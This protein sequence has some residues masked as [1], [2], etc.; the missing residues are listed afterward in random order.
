MKGPRYCSIIAVTS[1]AVWAASVAAQEHQHPPSQP[2]TP[3]PDTVTPLY[4]NLGSLHH[5]I[6]TKSPE[7]QRYFDQGLRLT[8]G[9]NHEE[10]VRSFERAVQLD[11]D[12]A[13]C[14]W[15]IAY[16]LG[17]NINLPMDAKIEPRALEA[18]RNAARLKGAVTAG[19]RAL[20]EAMAVRYGEPAG[21]SRAE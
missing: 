14:H 5:A 6:T 16:G 7:A 20:I 21:A 1:L 13:M 15:G 3:R 4:D 19:E 8:Y 10:A 12:C 9:F 17:P 2:T 11:P 18:S